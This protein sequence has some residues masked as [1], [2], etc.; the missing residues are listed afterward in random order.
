MA[1]TPPFPVPGTRYRPVD[2]VEID[3]SDSGLYDHPL[4]DVTEWFESADVQ[5]GCEPDADNTRLLFLPASG[6]LQLSNRT[7][8]FDTDRSIGELDRELELPHRCRFRTFYHAR[9]LPDG[10]TGQVL[11]WEGIADPPQV[12]SLG[13]ESIARFQLSGFQAKGRLD[14]IGLDYPLVT[15]IETVARRINQLASA[16]LPTDEPVG[17]LRSQN[18]GPFAWS[19]SVQALIDQFSYYMGGYVLDRKDGRLSF[20]NHNA[21]IADAANPSFTISQVDHLIRARGYSNRRRSGFVRNVASLGTPG[22]RDPFSATSQIVEATVDTTAMANDQTTRRF[23]S[24]LRLRWTDLPGLPAPDTIAAISGVRLEHLNDTIS[25]NRGSAVLLDADDVDEFSLTLTSLSASGAAHF[26][27]R[28]HADIVPSGP[29]Y[30]AVV[31]PVGARIGGRNYGAIWG[32]Y[33]SRG[34]PSGTTLATFTWDDLPGVPDRSQVVEISDVSAENVR[35]PETTYFPAGYQINI[36][37]PDGSPERFAVTLTSTGAT[38]FQNPIYAF[39]LRMNIRTRTGRNNFRNQSSVDHYGE[40]VQIGIP[41]WYTGAAADYQPTIDWL[42]QLGAP[43]GVLQMTLPRWQPTNVAGWQLDLLDVAGFYG[44]RLDDPTGPLVNARYLCVANRLSW[45]F[46]RQPVR[47][48]TFVHMSDLAAQTARWDE[49][50]WDEDLW[51][52]D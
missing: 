4:S 38:G 22:A 2:V 18:I 5:W 12:G 36:L 48:A 46:E 50:R 6:S 43:L 42:T 9:G 27:F 13:P 34:Q 10:Q 17:I 21:A 3:W 1:R 25:L 8:L 41:D 52:G 19:G 30:L 44:I 45:S 35:I 49:G 32:G 20:Y 28:V 16:P 51:G 47:Q 31:P 7:R 24:P 11:L 26:R 14:Q 23:T 29:S 15:S 40:R 37:N 39:R 33:T